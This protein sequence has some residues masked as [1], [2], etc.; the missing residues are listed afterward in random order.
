MNL[1]SDV[2]KRSYHFPCFVVV[3]VNIA[4]G[5]DAIT[6]VGLMMNVG[7]MEGAIHAIKNRGWCSIAREPNK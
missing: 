7:S 6:H 5:G 3:F 1:S 2:V 4:V